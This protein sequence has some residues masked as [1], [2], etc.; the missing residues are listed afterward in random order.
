M[1]RWSNTLNRRFPTEKNTNGQHMCI[2]IVLARVLQRNR[3]SMKYMCNYTGFIKQAFRIRGRRLPVASCRSEVGKSKMHIGEQEDPVAVKVKGL[4]AH[5][6]AWNWK[7]EETRDQCP[8]TTE[9]T[10]DLPNMGQA[11]FSFAFFVLSRLPAYWLVPP[12]F[13]LG[14]PASVCWLI[15]QSSSDMRKTFLICQAVLT[16]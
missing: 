5:S 7:V 15:C 14:L 13:R 16:N 6:R 9:K 3:I 11:I 8:K 10:R 2:C 1:E 12:S 4:K